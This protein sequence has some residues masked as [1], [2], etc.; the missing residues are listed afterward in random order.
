MFWG[1]GSVFPLYHVDFKDQT[2]LIKFGSRCF[3]LPVE[4]KSCYV[5]QADSQ[6]SMWDQRLTPTSQQ[7][8][9]KSIPAIVCG[10]LGSLESLCMCVCFQMCSPQRAGAEMV[11]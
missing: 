7:D 1:Q 2:Q 9:K 3:T 5:T 11:C 4:T 8:P 6:E 10:F